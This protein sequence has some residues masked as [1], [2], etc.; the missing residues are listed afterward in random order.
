MTGLIAR[1]KTRTAPPG[2]GPP[3]TVQP[4]GPERAGVALALARELLHSVEQFV[5]STP[6]LDTA[7]FLQRVR[8][9]ASGLTTRADA[10]TL[11][12]YQE[13][14]RKAITA[15]ATLQRRYLHQREEEMWR[16]LDT[17][18][19]AA[20]L[21]QHRDNELMDGIQDA[22]LRMRELSRLEDLKAARAGIEAE[23][24]R[25]RKLVD[26]KAQLDKEQLSNLA[27]EVHRLQSELSAVRGQANYDALTRVFHRGILQ[28]RLTELLGARKPC[29]LAIM[30][31]DD[32]K[33]INDTLGHHVGDRL[34]MLVGEQ[35]TRSA[36]SI[37]TVARFG[38]DEFCFLAPGTSPD[39]LVSR[40]AGA[41]SRRHARLEIEDRVISVLLSLSVGIAPSKEDDVPD[42]L[43]ARADAVLLNAK[44]QNRGGMLLAP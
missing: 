37:D 44:R 19:Q 29:S 27:R 3:A 13:W 34:L 28:D 26:R 6:D 30:D 40:I 4:S 23:I 16:L 31:L 33:T 15:Y 2:A 7:R 14:S 24:A 8:G 38:G 32:F 18:T 25:A 43:V 39:Q 42:A 22:H 21:G 17:Y 12:L 20:A 1:L 35:L 36:R 41:V 11:M 9:T 5:I 10:P